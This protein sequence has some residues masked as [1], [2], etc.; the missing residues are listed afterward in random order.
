ML[1]K[2]ETAIRV[3]AAYVQARRQRF[4]SRE[5]LEQWQDRRVESHLRYVIAHSEYHRKRFSG[6][7]MSDWRRFPIIDKRE[8][9]ANFSSYNT[10]SIDRDEAIRVARCAE[11]SRDYQPT[12]RGATVGLSS[13]TTGNYS[14]FLSSARENATFIGTALGRLLRGSLLANHRIAF[15]HRAHSNLYNGLDSGRMK[16]RFFDLSSPLEQHFPSLNELSPSQIIAPPFALRTLG[17][18]KRRGELIIAPRS[19]L[20]VAEVLDEDDKRQIETDF[21]LTID[22]AYIATEGFIAATC[23]YGSLHVNEDCLVMQREWIDRKSGHFVPIVTDFRRRAQPIIRYR[24]DDVLVDQPEPCAC[25]S[26]FAILERVEGRCDDVLVFRAKSSNTMQKVF[27]DFVRRAVGFASEHC[28][29]YRIVQN[30]PGE[31]HVAVDADPHHRDAAE[32]KV[33]QSLDQ[34][35]HKIGVTPPTVHF[36]KRFTVDPLKKRRRVVRD[37][38]VDLFGDN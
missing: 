36:D 24:L 2:A 30:S 37:F 21:Q 13:G 4:T 18:A 34:L 28:R 1:I 22:E 3:A 20:S 23:P 29:D 35:F 10:L 14:L 5:K 25:G 27:P 16:H 15:F 38:S 11:E 19:I 26:P 32:S 33:K 9:M 31:M 6:R 7:H 12:I 17:A 8:M